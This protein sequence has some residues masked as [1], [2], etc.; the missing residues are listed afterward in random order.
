MLIKLK[1]WVLFE[2]KQPLARQVKMDLEI[3]IA[4]SDVC[5]QLKMDPPIVYKVFSGMAFVIYET[6]GCFLLVGVILFEKYGG[7]PQKRSFRN[8]MISFLAYLVITNFKVSN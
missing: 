3:S 5:S 2:Y 1:S 6:F 4:S 8:R 7:D